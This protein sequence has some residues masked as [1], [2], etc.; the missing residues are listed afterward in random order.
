MSTEENW[1]HSKEMTP[2]ISPRKIF[3]MGKIEIIEKKWHQNY[4]HRKYSNWRN[5]ESLKINDTII[6]STE[7]TP[8][9]EN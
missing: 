3:L 6:I 5:L 7:N 4:F 8:T 9:G 1:N 2:E